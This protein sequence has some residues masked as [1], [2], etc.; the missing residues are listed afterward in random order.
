VAKGKNQSKY[1]KENIVL[2]GEIDVNY[3]LKS[4]NGLE[5]NAIDNI[6]L[7]NR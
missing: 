2:H 6:K 1:H 7:D 4:A 5:E 3:Q